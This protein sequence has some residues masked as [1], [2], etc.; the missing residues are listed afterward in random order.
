MKYQC[1]LWYVNAPPFFL[2]FSQNSVNRTSNLIE[3][4][5]LCHAV[6]FFISPIG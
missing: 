4:H 3:I 1:G 2:L 5:E 6:V